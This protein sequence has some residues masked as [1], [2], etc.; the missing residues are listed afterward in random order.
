VHVGRYLK[1]ELGISWISLAFKVD[2]G[3]ASKNKPDPQGATC[4]PGK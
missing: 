3:L 2:L 1:V 4:E